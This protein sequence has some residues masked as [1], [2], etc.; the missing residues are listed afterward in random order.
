MKWQ[1]NTC[2]KPKLVIQYILSLGKLCLLSCL[3]NSLKTEG[4]G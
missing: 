4:K 3:E 2:K 1:S